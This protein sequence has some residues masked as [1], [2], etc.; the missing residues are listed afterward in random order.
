MFTYFLHKHST[1]MTDSTAG[2]GAWVA[3][4]AEFLTARKKYRDRPLTSA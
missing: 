1:T 4:M 3:D 2:G